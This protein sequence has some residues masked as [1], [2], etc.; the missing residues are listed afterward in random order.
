MQSGLPIELHHYY[1]VPDK[2]ASVTRLFLGAAS[3]FL[4]RRK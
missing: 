3:L 1:A 2:P 4:R